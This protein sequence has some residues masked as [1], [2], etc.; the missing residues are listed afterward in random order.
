VPY[1]GSFYFDEKTF[2]S[3]PEELRTIIYEVGEEIT[4]ESRE[5][6]KNLMADSLKK[7]KEKNIEVIE[8]DLTEFKKATASMKE[9]YSYAKTILN[10]IEKARK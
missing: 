10:Y 4:K 3:Y 9:E 8:V 6:Y 1:E 5:I 7:L 2:Q